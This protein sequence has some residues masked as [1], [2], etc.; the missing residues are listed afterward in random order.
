MPVALC[1][2]NR[3]GRIVR[4]NQRAVELWGRPPTP[5][6]VARAP[7]E[8]VIRTAQP[9]RDL[10]FSSNTAMA[11]RSRREYG[12]ALSDAHGT[13]VA[14][15]ATI[16]EQSPDWDADVHRARLA[17]IVV[18]SDDAILSKTLDGIIESWNI[19]AERVFGYTAEEAVG[20]HISFII[21]P[22]GSMKKPRCSRV[23]AA[24]RGS[25]TSKRFAAPRMAAS[26]TSR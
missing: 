23:C 12:H 15:I 22:I 10:P 4:Y 14:A 9:L 26:L 13:T 11:A 21:P 8:Q 18:S 19:G 17:A 7:L 6:D 3:E 2:I 25:I 5:S 16:L 1:V 20:Q 24:A